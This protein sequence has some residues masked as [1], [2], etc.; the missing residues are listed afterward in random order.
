VARVPIP[1]LLGMMKSSKVAPSWPGISLVEYCQQLGLKAG[2]GSIGGYWTLGHQALRFLG[3][4]I[5]GQRNIIKPFL[6]IVGPKTSLVPETGEG[7]AMAALAAVRAA[8]AIGMAALTGGHR[9]WWHEYPDGGGVLT[10]RICG[11]NRSPKRRCTRSPL[12]RLRT[13]G[14]TA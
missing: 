2:L 12:R 11:S 14:C 7:S 13:V 10:Y 1:V 6:V 9:N 3:L 5:P 8:T 4:G